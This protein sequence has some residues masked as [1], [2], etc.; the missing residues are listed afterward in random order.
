MA[1]KRKKAGKRKRVAVVSP[2]HTPSPTPTPEESPERNPQL[3]STARG[4]TTRSGQVPRPTLLVQPPRTR[5]VSANLMESQHLVQ[6][7]ETHTSDQISPELSREFQAFLAYRAS[8]QHVLRSQ[9]REASPT[10]ENLTPQARPAAHLSSQRCDT[11][12]GPILFLLFAT[13][14]TTPSSTA[15][16]IDPST[17]GDLRRRTPAAPT[18]YLPFH[19]LTTP[20][21]F[22]H[23]IRPAH[24]GLHSLAPRSAIALGH[25][26]T[27]AFGHSN[28][29]KIRTATRTT[30]LPFIGLPTWVCTLSPLIR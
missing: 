1:P 3:T 13:F 20:F 11:P 7:T 29:H 6:P 28:T 5:S 4:V 19:S 15:H 17:S 18:T 12:R 23:G 27:R 9:Q 8:H 26:A 22:N 21:P 2:Q 25:S 24:V 30:L 10:E 16:E 14:A